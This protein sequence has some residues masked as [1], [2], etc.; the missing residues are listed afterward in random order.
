MKKAVF[1]F[2][3]WFLSVF[4][5]AFVAQADTLINNF[6]TARNYV[7]NGII[8]ENNWDGIHLNFGSV[9]FGNNDGQ[10]AN[11][12]V[13]DETTFPGYLGLRT[14]G[15]DWSGANDDGFF[16]Y[17]VVSGDFDVAVQS[18]PFTL[19]GGLA[20]DNRAN[21][22][23]GLLARAYNTNNSDAPFSTTLTT[24]SENWAGLF[25]MNQYGAAGEIR[26]ATNG[27]NREITYSNFGGVDS[28]NLT[29]WL[30]ITR[31][32][33]TLDFYVKTSL[34]D[35]WTRIT[36]GL[37]TSGGSYVRNDWAGIP[38]QVG[39]AASSFGTAQR[40]AVFTDFE[41]TGTNVT[42]PA[43]PP[44]P[45]GLV[46]TGT[47][48]TGALT[49]SWTVGNSG[50]RSL[51][52][53]KQGGR[54]QQNPI[55][56]ITYTANQAFGDTNTL[57][58]G[59]TYVVYDGTGNNITVSNLGGNN[60]TYDVA[61][62]EYTNTASPV[63]NTASP[64]LTT[65]AGP[66]IITGVI[67]TIAPTNIP[68]G[69][70]TLGTLLATFSSGSATVDES[71]VATWTSS[72]PTIAYFTG[73]VLTALT[74]GTV[75]VTGSF[76]GF[77][78]SAT[79]TVTS[80][81]FTDN[82]ATTQDYIAS[83]VVGSAWDG[84]FLNYGDVPLTTA[85][86]NRKG[87]DAA[88]GA[89]SRFIANTNVLT[90]EAAGSTWAVAGNDGPF[91]YKIVTGDFQA[92]VHV[93]PQSTINNCDSG[94]MARIYNN[95]GG[96]L[97]GGGG[98]AGGTET[99]INW[100]KVQNGTPAVRRTIDS[101]GTTVVNGLNATDRWFLM[102][103]INSTN[104]LMFESSNPTNAGWSFVTS[105]VV[106]EAANNAPMEVGLMQEMRT[107]SD[108]SV[109]MDNF[110]VDGLG[111]T[112]PA[113]PPPAATKTT[114]TLNGDL[115]M[116]FNW[117]V[118]VVSGNA[119]RSLLVMHAGAPV[120][121]LPTLSQAASIGGTG[122]PVNFGTGLSLGD[123]NYMVFSTPGGLTPSQTNTTVT[124]NNLTPGVTYYAVV[125]T[126]V[127][128]GGSK[129]FN[130]IIPP[131]GA[132]VVQ[133]DGSLLSIQTLPL[134]P[135][136]RGGVGQLQVIGLFSGGASVN[137]SAFADLTS[138]NTNIVTIAS[139]VLTG[140]ANGTNTVQVIYGGF[141]NHATVTVRDPGFTDSY[142][143]SHDYLN[144]GVSG[145]PYDGVYNPNGL[146]PNPG[147]QVPESTYVPPSFSGA[148]VADA[149]T[150]SNGVLTLVS[151]GDGWENEA[152]GG[153]FLFKYMP[154]DFQVAVHLNSFIVSGYN[155]PGL[156]AR[157]Y[158]TG[159]NGTEVGSPFVLGQSTNSAGTTVINGES[160]VSLC[161]FDEF[162]IGTY[163]RLNLDS[164]VLQ[165]TQGDTAPGDTN[166][167]LLIVRSSGTNFNFYKR[168]VNTEA[169]K[170]LPLK[171]SYQVGEFA[172]VPM[173]VGIMAGP[174]NGGA[175][176]NAQFDSYMLDYTTGSPLKIVNTGGGNVTVSWPAGPTAQLQST[177]NLSPPVIWQT[178]P[179]TPTLDISGYNLTVPKTNAATF[180]RLVQ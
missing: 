89:T 25:R 64:S 173:Q 112:P 75:S 109:I 20:Y 110:M 154:G 167:W 149:N 169:W 60:L 141:T 8:G 91:L 135:I 31:A 70:A 156:L 33:N 18:S 16:I 130:D 179:G 148:T 180:F 53:M 15:T 146:G 119:A 161:R 48:I 74:N 105:L 6:T 5:F 3:A 153:F 160:W 24:R 123:G 136:P 99:H 93:G 98:G 28:T 124:V 176:Y 67:T 80:P 90:I 127:G 1:K 113:T 37:A 69:G 45:S 11:T 129:S 162:G 36:N 39:I 125:V 81:A 114:V 83:G 56:G 170:P 35:P 128:S 97:Q 92:S 22:F 115:S 139:G 55:N 82:F 107:A 164:S 76:G 46:T 7:V 14:S 103:R 108:G 88:A 77:T 49:F 68:V 144:N 13:A 21:N 34:G 40:D 100:V 59:S 132:S 44:A 51:I 85:V 63:Y 96:A 101:G 19:S 71:A 10:L 147:V 137:V 50:D 159:T 78:A 165:S 86:D 168:S 145:T 126:Y 54:I 143:T 43:V 133:K 73:S 121:A 106:A 166:Y 42:F 32:N 131:T 2:F 27:A 142:G 62:Y 157:A 140:I 23:C 29:H 122:T 174:W 102:Q 66:G 155:M 151:A 72:D 87:N 52:I 94:I 4:A 111:I 152:S 95:A 118:P 12:A 65:N 171:T 58:G 38:L 57:I 61:V 47:N 116:T 79:I 150:T 104:F 117:V 175:Q 26:L 17:K 41:L 9:P 84:L 158:T 177:T 172:G 178:V 138:G 120:T 30:R 134:P 163:A